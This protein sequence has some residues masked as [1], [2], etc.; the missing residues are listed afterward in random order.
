MLVILIQEESPPGLDGAGHPQGLPVDWD[1][2]PH[3]EPSRPRSVLPLSLPSAS[4]APA[5]R[6]ASVPQFPAE[7][8]TQT[9]VH[10]SVSKYY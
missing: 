9:P 10:S 1:P 8:P 4:P 3:A 6:A 7:D 5:L 2:N